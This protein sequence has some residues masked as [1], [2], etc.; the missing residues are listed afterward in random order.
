[1]SLLGSQLAPEDIIGVPQVVDGKSRFCPPT[2]IARDHRRWPRFSS[3]VTTHFHRRWPP[4]S[5]KVATLKS[6]PN[7]TRGG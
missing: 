2:I 1:V 4:V 5:T 7:G 3:K 6:S